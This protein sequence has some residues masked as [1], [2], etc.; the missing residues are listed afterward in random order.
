MV[1]CYGYLMPYEGWTL[2]FSFKS[3]YSCA[4]E[5]KRKALRPYPLKSY[6]QFARDLINSLKHVTILCCIWAQIAVHHR[7]VRQRHA[8]LRRGGAAVRDTAPL[9]LRRRAAES[10]CL[11]SLQRGPGQLLFAQ[12]RPWV[13]FTEARALRVRRRSSFV[14][15]RD[16]GMPG[17][18]V[19]VSHHR[20]L[21]PYSYIN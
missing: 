19:D 12:V 13:P 11:H 2:S 6:L 17:V 4:C 7:R 16:I 9:C 1:S 8:D 5:G 10:R 15:I 20:R 18:S 3:R 14:S 21:Q